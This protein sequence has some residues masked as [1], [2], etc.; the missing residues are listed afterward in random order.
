MDNGVV[1]AGEN[2]YITSN[3]KSAQKDYKVARS[4]PIQDLLY[5]LID[6]V[7]QLTL[8][9]KTHKHLGSPAMVLDPQPDFIQAVTTI[10]QTITQIQD[11]LGNISSP[12]VHIP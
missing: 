8:A 12:K 5:G 10:E 6:A 11:G 2:V 4:E 9:L 1:I 3:T 7:K